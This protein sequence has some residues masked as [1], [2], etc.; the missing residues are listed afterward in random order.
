MFQDEGT[1]S[2]KALKQ[3][4]SGMSRKRRGTGKYLSVLGEVITGARPCRALQT[5]MVT[6]A[7]TLCG[8]R[9]CSM[10]SNGRMITI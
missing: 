5:I 6:L 10:V 8:M 9:G 7:F 3:D 4:V 2:A 1:V